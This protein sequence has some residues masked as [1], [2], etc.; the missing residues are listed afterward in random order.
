VV[1][2]H[3]GKVD[4]ITLVIYYSGTSPIGKAFGQVEPGLIDR[5]YRRKK[6]YPD[7]MR[8]LDRKAR[9]LAL[10]ARQSDQFVFDSEQLELSHRLQRLIQMRI[11]S[12]GKARQD[13]SAAD[14][15]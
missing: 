5:Y 14:E 2:Q 11:R 3:Q 10:E 1:A 15:D 8:K 4:D 12:S 13:A 6:K 9:R 7:E